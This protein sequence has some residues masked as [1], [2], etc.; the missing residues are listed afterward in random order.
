MLYD[1]EFKLKWKLSYI[2]FE[3]FNFFYNLHHPRV[4]WIA[5]SINFFASVYLSFTLTQL[6][7]SS[8]RKLVKLDAVQFVLNNHTVCI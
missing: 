4:C 6:N 3:K 5:I 1:I 7:Y 2:G 8:A